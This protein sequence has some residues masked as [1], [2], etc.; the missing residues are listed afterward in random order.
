[1]KH[2]WSVKIIV[3]DT[4]EDGETPYGKGPIKAVFD[5]MDLPAGISIKV[6]E[7]KKWKIKGRYRS[8]TTVP[9]NEDM[10]K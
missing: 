7:P 6:M 2:K 9:Y 1:M 8:S 4:P 3:T 10:V 5:D